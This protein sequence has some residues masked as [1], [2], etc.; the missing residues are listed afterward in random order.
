MVSVGTGS[1]ATVTMPETV[2]SLIC[3]LREKCLSGGINS[4]KGLSTVFRAM[5]IDYSKR[6]VIEEL[7][8]GLQKYG[9][10]MSDSYLQRL[11]EALDVNGSGGIDFCEFMKQLRPPMLECRIKVVNEAFDKLDVNQNGSIEIDDLSGLYKLHLL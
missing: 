8:D 6:I 1:Q 5:D 10:H 3:V 4:I 11:F 7:K 2:E 9:I